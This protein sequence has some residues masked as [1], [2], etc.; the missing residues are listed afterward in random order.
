MPS[1]PG[2]GAG[3]D[4]DQRKSPTGGNAYGRDLVNVEYDGDDAD[5]D[6]HDDDADV[7]DENENDEEPEGGVWKAISASQHLT[8]RP[9]LGKNHFLVMT[10][11]II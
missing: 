8:H 1:Q 4:F 9:P 11:I 6:N 10:M 2:I 5:V 7:E 3:K